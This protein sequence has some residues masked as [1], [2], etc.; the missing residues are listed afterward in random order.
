MSISLP[1]SVLSLPPS[2]TDGSGASLPAPDPSDKNLSDLEMG[3]GSSDGE[4]PEAVD[5]PD[6]DDAGNGFDEAVDLPDDSDDDNK[7]G[8]NAPRYPQ[9]HI[10]VSSQAAPLNLTYLTLYI[11]NISAYIAP[12]HQNTTDSTH[13]GQTIRRSHEFQG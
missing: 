4:L 13:P 9:V 2:V 10:F 3:G 7:D 5:L 11:S 8:G 1:P 6:A 12:A